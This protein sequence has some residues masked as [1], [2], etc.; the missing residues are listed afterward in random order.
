M[1]PRRYH[2][3][4]NTKSNQPSAADLRRAADLSEKIEAL[5]AEIESIL[6]GRK[7]PGPKRKAG[8]KKAAR[9]KAGKKRNISAAGREAIRLA[10][11]KRWAK[12]R[13]AKKKAAKG[14]TKK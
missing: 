13:A 5:Q 1:V 2:H 9:K 7:K 8:K 3:G 12:V 10:Q 11:Q 4:M 14:K 6:S